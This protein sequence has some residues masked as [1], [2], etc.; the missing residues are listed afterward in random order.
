MVSNM[1]QAEMDIR[2]Q[3]SSGVD[4]VRL[5]GIG[6]V[7]VGHA[8]PTEPVRAIAFTWHVPLFFFLSGYLWKPGRDL[9]AEARGRWRTL[10][11]PYVAWLAL[12][13]AVL[14]PILLVQDGPAA[15]ARRAVTVV[16]GG[17]YLTSPFQAFWFVSCLLFACLLMRALE[18]WWPFG[19]TAL[20]A[21]LLAVSVVA[22]PLSKVPLGAGVAIPAVIF[23]LAGQ[24]ASRAP[25][26]LRRP[27]VASLALLV[28]A[29]VTALG[30]NTPLNLKGGD[31]GV[32]VLGVVVAVAVCAALT[33]LAESMTPSSRAVTA[34]G[35]IGLVVVLTHGVPVYFL[36][37]RLG[38]WPT[39][40]V[41]LAVGLACGILARR[42]PGSRYLLGR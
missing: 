23:L 2:T 25:R 16:L 24:A 20:V 40:G 22:E 8:V 15:A 5:L 4:L 6:A 29:A 32:P 3:R 18:R 37:D 11:I 42:A 1:T 7:V 12:V 39:A 33:Y 30:W 36:G 31:F 41:A 35:S 38:P 34:V 19:V 21:L 9:G 28:A 14:L 26:P 27:A 10:A 13:S 17:S